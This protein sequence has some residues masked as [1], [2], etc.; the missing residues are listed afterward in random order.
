MSSVS[1]L[2]GW[3]ERLVDQLVFHWD[4]HLR[5]RLDGLTD[6]EYRWEPVPGCWGVRPRAEARAELVGG[7][8]DVVW[9]YEFPEP[10]PVPVTT[11]AWRLAHLIV[12]VFGERNHNHFGGPEIRFM[13]HDYAATATA[14]LAQLD[15]GYRRW[16]D[17]CR[18]LGP[19]GLARPV[20]EAEGPFAA[21]PYADLILHINREV[22]HHGA[23]ILT[24]RDLY[25]TGP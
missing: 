11:I 19:A 14:A 7:R 22:I 8:G 4:H 15:D 13:T 12:Q 18:S 25:R 23:E 21:S 3:N 20:G 5:P 17:R 24:L 9:E 16:I 1:S 10:D 2:E 6:D